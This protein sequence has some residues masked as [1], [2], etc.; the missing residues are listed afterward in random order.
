MLRGRRGA[1]AGFSLAELIVAF[2]LLAILGA[3][4]TR[5]MV[6]QGRFTDQ[7]NALRNARTV[8]RQGMN[9]LMSEARMVQDSL[10]V[11]SASS[12][13]K[14]IR[15]VVPYR[16]GMNCGV[17]GTK[18]VVSML[19]V[20]SL[21]LVQAVY[22]G[23]AYRNQLGAYT[24]PVVPAPLTTDAPTASTD[25]AQCTGSGAGQAQIRT[26]TLGGRAGEVLDI[27]PAVA[28]PTAPKGQAVFFYQRVT[29]QFKA[30]A[31]FPGWNGLYRSVEGG[32]GDELV[33]PFDTSARF[34]Y[35]TAAATASV[36]SPP[37][38]ALIRGID[39]VFVGRSS[40]TPMGKTV[41]SKT[42]VVA[43]IFFKNVRN[44]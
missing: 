12:D 18:N 37:A 5:I 25:A 34:K 36:S 2:T 15:L 27:S 33:A 19:P 41:P 39:I 4:F 7:Q 42:T 38:L 29:Y 40:Y 3:T 10:G 6:T 30:S 11:D 44:F 24:M 22:A 31:A 20:D 43:S 23:W 32:T 9:V 26:I 8:S 13:G 21:A 28:S 35:W 14:T 17:S 1:R 16:F